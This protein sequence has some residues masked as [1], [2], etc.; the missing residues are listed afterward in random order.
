MSNQDKHMLSIIA[1]FDL[2]NYPLTAWELWRFGPTKQTYAENLQAIKE[3]D[4]PEQDGFYFLPDRE[5]IVITKQERYNIADKKFK[6][7]LKIA[8]LMSRLPWIKLVALVN[9]IGAHNLRSEGDLDFFIVTQKNRLWLSRLI[10]TAVLKILRLRPTAKKSRDAICLS[11]WVD[12]AHLNLGAFRLPDDWY[13]RYWLAG[14]AP[15]YDRAD[16][17]KKLISANPWLSQALP[18]WQPAKIS[19]RRI[20]LPRCVGRVREGFEFPP[21][22][23]GEVRRGSN[24]F[25]KLENL[26]KNFQWKIMPES[27]KNLA[28]QDTRVVINEGV[29][30]MHPVDRRKEFAEKHKDNLAKLGYNKK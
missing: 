24:I 1:F 21:L 12:E 30:K 25:N 5:Q 15:L 28:N 29:I 17:Y 23:K 10:I 3:A 13:F 2:F 19:S 20:L 7:A 16:I 6:R 4:L 14:L 8:W 11:F 27:L 26:V 22:A 9:L 18:N